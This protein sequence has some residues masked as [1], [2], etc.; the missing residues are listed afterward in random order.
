MKKIRNAVSEDKKEFRSLWDKC[1]TDSIVF[2]DW[3]FEN[4]FIPEYS[5]CMEEDNKIVSE[6][7]SIPYFIKIRNAIIPAT[8]M[9]G[10]CT[11]PDYT[12]RGYMKELYTWYMN[13]VKDLGIVL[14]A[15]TPAVLHT[16]F[17]VGHFPVS[18]TAFIEIEKVEKTAD[19]ADVLE[20]DMKNESAAFLKCYSRF[21]QNYSGIILRTI[22]DMRL[23]LSDYAADGGKAIAVLEN[24]E[25]LA[26]AVY[27][28]TEEM[29]HGEEIVSLNQHAEQKIVNKLIHLGEGKKVKIKLP[30][31]TKSI[32]NQGVVTISPRNV[33]GLANVSH[34]LRAVGNNLS[35]AI[36]IEDSVVKENNGI[37]NLKGEKTKELPVFKTTSGNLIQWLCGYKSIEELS[38]EGSLEVYNKPGAE[39]LDNLFPKQACHIID[40]Y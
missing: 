38:N 23:K 17:Y 11:H 4:R 29:L 13:Y 24:G 9:V 27:Y 16:Y 22:S 5:I 8:M 40:E 1:F 34:L 19:E 15:H 18:S 33:L 14:C 7:Q 20:I 25:V 35:I 31:D 12:K 2:R 3:F 30:P 26:Y 36:E 32:S 21:A 6:V 10:A 28:D 37:F 39:V